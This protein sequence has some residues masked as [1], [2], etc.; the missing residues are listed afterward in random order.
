MLAAVRALGRATAGEVAAHSGQ[1]NG[2][3][4]VALRALVG[5][6]QVARTET[7][8][9][10]EYSLVSPGDIKPFKRARR[11]VPNASAEAPA[12]G[13][14]AEGAGGGTAGKRGRRDVAGC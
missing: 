5:H 14:V 9:G 4:S 11:A 8:R 3:T 7:S 6:G 10:V 1:P 12:N 13:D 2:S